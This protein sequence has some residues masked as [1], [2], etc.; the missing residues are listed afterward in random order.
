MVLKG[1]PE[2]VIGMCSFYQHEGRKVPI[3]EEF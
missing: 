3:D 1:A 2:R